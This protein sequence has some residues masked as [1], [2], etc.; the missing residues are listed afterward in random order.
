L[1]IAV[2]N[3][4]FE[5]RQM[6]LSAFLP[7]PV[8]RYVRSG[9]VLGQRLLAM[10]GVVQSEAAISSDSQDYWRS[11]DAGWWASNSHWRDA[12][13]FAGGDLWDRIGQRHLEMLEVVAGAAPSGTGWRRVV[14]WGCG[15]GANAVHIAP[16]CTEF[17]GVEVAPDSLEECRR[18][19][20]AVCQTPFRPILIDVADPEQALSAIGEPCDLFVSFYVFEL[21]PTPEYG[22]RILRIAAQLLAPGG[23]VLVQVK[24]DDGTWRTRARRRNYCFGV[25]DMTTYP[26][27]QFWEMAAASGLEPQAVRLRPRDELDERYA[28]FHLR[29]VPDQETVTDPGRP[30]PP[31]TPILVEDL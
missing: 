24:Y 4:Y 1:S 18:Q 27:A 28:Y 20:G 3:R 9:L 30:A 22:Q 25:G 15:G 12:P 17:I 23:H 29:K 10:A 13:V 6:N 14:E 26:I 31:P 19:V 2:S 8:R 11:P 7:A 16:R 21:L 5:D